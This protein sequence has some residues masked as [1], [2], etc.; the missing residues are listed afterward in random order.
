MYRNIEQYYLNRANGSANHVLSNYD[1]NY[2]ATNKFCSQNPSMIGRIRNQLIRAINAQQTFPKLVILVL[3]DDLLSVIDKNRRSNEHTIRKMIN[4]LMR[5]FERIVEAQKELLPEK[6]KKMFYPHFMWV[7]A[8][9]HK[10]FKNNELRRNFNKI[11]ADTAKL[12]SNT[13]VF[14][15]K[16]VWDTEDSNYFLKEANR[17]TSEGLIAYWS[18]IDRTTKFCDSTLMKKFAKIEF[19]NSNNKG[20]GLNNQLRENKTEEA[21]SYSKNDDKVR[22]SP[23]QQIDHHKKGKQAQRKLPPPPF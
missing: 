14:Q 19:K 16:K 7:E 23:L 18:A 1:V 22:P 12:Y 17:F 20:F 11:L 8:P 21:Y 9:H 4:W 2:Y 6:A 3:D 5:Q 10:Y 13:S 15:L